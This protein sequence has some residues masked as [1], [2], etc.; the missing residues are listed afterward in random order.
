MKP[1]HEPTYLRNVLERALD[2]TYNF[3]VRYFTIF[4]SNGNLSDAH[5]FNSPSSLLM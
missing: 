1:Y 5:R 2:V 4:S 3:K